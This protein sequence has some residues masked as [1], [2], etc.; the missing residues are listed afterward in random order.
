[1]EEGDQSLS[2]ACRVEMVSRVAS[3]VR[4]ERQRKQVQ[5]KWKAWDRWDW[6]WGV[7]SR[8]DVSGFCVSGLGCGYEMGRWGWEKV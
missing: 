8:G 7:G 6:R 5:V 4:A 2:A 3:V 1:M